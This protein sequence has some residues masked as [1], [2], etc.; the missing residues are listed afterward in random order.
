MYR[1][2]KLAVVLIT[3]ILVTASLEVDASAQALK[4]LQR[5]PCIWYPV[6]FHEGKLIRPLIDSGSEI[7][8]ITPA[9][10]AELGFTARKTSIR[11][12]KIDSSPLETHG[13]VS[14]RFSLQNSLGKVWFCEETF[15]LADTS[16]EVVLRMLF[17][18]LSNA[19]VKF[20]ELEK[21]TWRSYI[22]AGALPITSWVELINKREFAKTVLD[23]NSETFVIYVSALELL[24]AMWIHPSRAPQVL[25]DPT[26]AAL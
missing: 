19:N 7:N 22:L 5:V 4:A 6:W 9:Y 25:D 10:A 11:A 12:Q 21:F 8:A 13:I 3:F 24:T 2:K 26:L 1:A 15:L 14:A 16:M 17:L 18:S 20:A 23:K